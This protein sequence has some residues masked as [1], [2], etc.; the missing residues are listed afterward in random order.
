[1]KQLQDPY[2][3][4][5]RPVLTEKSYDQMNEGKYTFM[6]DVNANKYQIKQAIETVFKVKVDKVN[7]LRQQGKVKRMGRNEGRRPSYKKA[8]V[9]LKPGSKIEFFEGMAQ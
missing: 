1:M 6:V 8:I 7:T 4:I 2:D 5:K 9:K 3:I